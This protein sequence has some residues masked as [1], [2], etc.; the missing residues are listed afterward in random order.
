MFL[1][2]NEFFDQTE[3]RSDVRRDK[4]LEDRIWQAEVKIVGVPFFI[5]TLA[6]ISLGF[7][8]DKGW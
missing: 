6:R 1:W 4:E 7:I 5:R 3:V 2:G 8:E